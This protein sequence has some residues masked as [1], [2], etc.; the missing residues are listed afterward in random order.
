MSTAATNSSNSVDILLSTYN[1]SSFLE[2]QIES[3]LAQ[4]YT[5]WR[6]LVRDDG[7][8]DSTVELIE[9]YAL[10]HPDRIVHIE[11]TEGT[12][13]PTLSFSRL[14]ESSTAEYSLFCDQDDV[15]EAD[16]IEVTLERMQRIESELGAIPI[17]VH[18]DL[19]VVGTDLSILSAS[20]WKY[21]NLDPTLTTLK[22][23]LLLN[24]VT[25]CTVMLNRPLRTIAAPIPAEAVLHDWWLALVASAFGYIGHVDTPTVL[26]RQHGANVAGSTSYSAGYFFSRLR[27]LGRTTGLL[28]RIVAQATVF[29]SVYKAK[30]V[31]MD[32][33]MVT[34]FASLLSTSR[35]ARVGLLLKHGFKGTGLLRN[36]GIYMLL[37]FMES[38]PK[39]AVQDPREGGVQK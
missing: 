38:A 17:L 9:Q 1:G 36:A 19:K 7:S 28:R 22:N 35:G 20:F 11:D 18:T 25:G 30:F 31:P 2:P 13:G 29:L 34:G 6:L 23:L 16:K 32:L 12:L 27:S 5:E 3:L 24:N 8:T 26:Y 10:L 37:L 39:G 14:L 21:Q 4:S 33:K 15:W